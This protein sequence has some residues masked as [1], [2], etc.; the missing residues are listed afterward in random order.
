M[1]KVVSLLLILCFLFLTL[2]ACGETEETQASETES[3]SEESKP[4]S[5]T[6]E[7]TDEYNQNLFV[8]AVPVDELDFDGETITILMRD[9]EDICREW[10]K[11]V[12]GDDP[13]RS[14]DRHE[15]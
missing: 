1:K 10:G 15:K 14:G 4:L 7:E 13:P 9:G 11:E 12:I 6:L 8:S 2:I 5:G 3:S